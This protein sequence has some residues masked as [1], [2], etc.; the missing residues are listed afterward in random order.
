MQQDH[1]SLLLHGV[2]RR[3][4][5][6]LFFL[7]YKRALYYLVTCV[8]LTLVMS[9]PVRPHD[10]IEIMDE[11]DNDQ[12]V[13]LEDFMTAEELN[14]VLQG[15][16]AGT[17]SSDSPEPEDYLDPSLTAS[18]P[19]PIMATYEQCL[20]DVLD[21]FPDISHEHVKK[22]YDGRDQIEIVAPAISNAGT[23]ISLILDEGEYPRERDRLNELKRKRLSE[24]DD[25]D[26]RAAEWKNAEHTAGE[27]FYSMHA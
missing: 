19:P 12:D 25:D 8:S 6:S 17:T 10:I 13:R 3:Q 9:L 24:L 23:L 21:V 26:E 16:V 11:S 7:C 1:Q 18:L 4:L 15:P 2:T 22:L 27:S 14:N 20:R 5:G